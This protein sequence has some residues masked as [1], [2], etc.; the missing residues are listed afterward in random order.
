MDQRGRQS[1]SALTTIAPEH[2]RPDPPEY[3]KPDEAAEWNAIVGRM[4]ADWF[5]R[6]THELLIRYLQHRTTARKLTKMIDEIESE[7]PMD[8]SKYAKM[9]RLRNAESG[10]LVNIARAMRLT[11]HSRL[12]AQTAHTKANQGKKAQPWT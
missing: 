10:Q 5:T 2:I 12:K 4:P 11:Q 9:V 3:L 7:E 1:A 8:E 6:E